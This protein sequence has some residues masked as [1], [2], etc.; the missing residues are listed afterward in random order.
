MYRHGLTKATEIG[1]GRREG[2]IVDVEVPIN[3]KQP[4]RQCLR[5]L[6]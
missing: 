6:I 3:G 1:P 5:E 4:I 2:I